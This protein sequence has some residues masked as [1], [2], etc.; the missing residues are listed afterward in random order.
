MVLFEVNENSK[1]QSVIEEDEKIE[2]LDDLEWQPDILGK[3]ECIA[4]GFSAVKF[5][6]K[7]FVQLPLL[8]LSVSRSRQSLVLH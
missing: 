8:G 1:P 2:D 4:N 3:L 7:V 5:H 6:L